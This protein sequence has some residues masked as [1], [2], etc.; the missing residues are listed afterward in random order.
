MRTP[1][2]ADNSERSDPTETS[3]L[4]APQGA[5]NATD[6]SPKHVNGEVRNDEEAQ[7][8][9]IEDDGKQAQ[10]QGFIEAQKKLKYIVPAISLG[11]CC[12][13]GRL[14]LEALS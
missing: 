7:S 1:G 2:I 14:L 4:L 6:Q 11:V 3:P 5:G 9:E 8:D 13:Y 10:F 12:N